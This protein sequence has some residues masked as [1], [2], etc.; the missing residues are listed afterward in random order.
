M[1]FLGE[2][3]GRSFTVPSGYT[4]STLLM[5]FAGTSGPPL[6]VDSTRTSRRDPLTRNW[7]QRPTHSLPTA[8]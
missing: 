3:N 1:Q 4:G 8:C 2:L 6:L 7:H 5:S